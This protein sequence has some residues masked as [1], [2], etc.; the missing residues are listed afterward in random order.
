M[1]KEALT[2]I[3]RGRQRSFGGWSVRR[4]SRST[5]RQKQPPCPT[6]CAVSALFYGVAFGA[7]WCPAERD[8]WRV[9]G[10]DARS[11]KGC[12]AE[13]DFGRREMV[14][15]PDRRKDAPRLTGLSV[16]GRS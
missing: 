14:W 5:L 1:P 4:A 3:P 2:S 9:V 13:A 15:I 7:I 12:L 11:P 16:G 6:R 10:P 8:V